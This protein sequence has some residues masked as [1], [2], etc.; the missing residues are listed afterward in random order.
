MADCSELFLLLP[1][2]THGSFSSRHTTEWHFFQSND[3]RIVHGC[4][5]F[6]VYVLLATPSNWKTPIVV[7]CYVGTDAQLLNTLHR[8][9]LSVNDYSLPCPLICLSLDIHGAFSHLVMKAV[10]LGLLFPGS[11]MQ[12]F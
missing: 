5:T 4:G 9:S 2:T 8:S 11:E 3:L 12:S 7:Q 10:S 1:W 6:S